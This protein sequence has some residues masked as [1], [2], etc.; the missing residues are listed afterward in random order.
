[1]IGNG[2]T[3]RDDGNDTNVDGSINDWNKMSMRQ[4]LD[5]VNLHKNNQAHLEEGV[6]TPTGPIRIQVPTVPRE[7]TIEGN[8][9]VSAM[10]TA[11]WEAESNLQPSNASTGSEDSRY[12]RLRRFSQ[13]QIRHVDHSDIDDTPS[14]GLCGVDFPTRSNLFV[15]LLSCV[16][17]V[18]VVAVLLLATGVIGSES[19]P[20]AQSPVSTAP[21]SL[22][23]PSP[24]P[25][26]NPTMP[27]VST[28]PVSLVFPSP[29]AT[30]NP[31]MPPVSTAPVSLVFP[32]PNPTSNPTMP[33]ISNL[34]TTPP[35]LLP[36]SSPLPTMMPPTP[37]SPRSVLVVRILGDNGAE[38]P[39]ETTASLAG[40]IFGMGNET[41]LNSMRAQFNRCSFGKLDFVP[42]DGHSLISNGVLDVAL[43][44]S[45]EGRDIY[46]DR[47]S[48]HRETAALLGVSSLGLGNTFDHVMFCVAAGTV[49]SVASFWTSF[50][51][52]ET[53]SY[54]NSKFLGC[55]RLSALM[56]A[57]GHNLGLVNSGVGDNQYGDTTGTVR[58]NAHAC[59][60]PHKTSHV[61]PSCLRYRW[62]QGKEKCNLSTYFGSLTL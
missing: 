11:P 42:A 48:Y 31:T 45:L 44:L 16:S 59:L 54:F 15:T 7:V 52:G 62:E 60:A 21:V 4:S 58:T 2:S 23:F 41:F 22:V 5:H 43:N 13:N 30:S 38:Q 36:T 57:M 12:M 33:P 27:L 20:V 9:V 10:S 49:S 1:M 50:S 51:A 24:K 14:S 28:A 19:D 34:K 26:S 35:T 25:T 6:P 17:I 8:T 53:Y 29:K 47:S 3:A 39:V 56:L 61:F 46:R 55:E 40:A 37:T 18:L 32:S